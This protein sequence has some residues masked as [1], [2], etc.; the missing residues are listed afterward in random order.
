MLDDEH[1]READTVMTSSSTIPS[2][3]GGEPD[4][5]NNGAVRARLPGDGVYSTPHG[6]ERGYRVGNVGVQSSSNSSF[7]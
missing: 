1:I 6:C 4:R 3:R 5:H 2:L 7:V